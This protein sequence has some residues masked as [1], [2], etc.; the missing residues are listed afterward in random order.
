VIDL[1]V[2]Y[3]ITLNVSEPNNNIGLLKIRQ[4]D[5][6]T[7]TL[8]VQILEDALPKSYE[9]LEVF[10]CARIGQTAGLGIIEQKLH[11]SEMTDPKNGKLEYTFR[12]EDWQV[13]GRQNGYFSFRKMNDDHEYVQQFSTR[14]FTYEITK[15][16]YSDGIKEVKKDGST[17]IWTFEDLL[18]LLQEFK[19][20]GE[21]DFLEWFEE[22]R[23]QLSEDAAGNL[24]L[25]Y[26]SLR[27][28]TGTDNDFRPLE[29]N[30]SYMQ[31]VF[32]DA[33]ERA[34]PI[35]WYGASEESEDN[36]QAIQDS[37]DYCYSIGGGTVLIPKGTFKTSNGI[38]LR[39]GVNIEGVGKRLS[40]LKI[41]D[42]L[43]DWSEL[44][45]SDKTK[46]LTDV[47]IRKVG[48]D[49]NVE[50]LITKTEQWGSSARV[51][52]R[53][54]ESL[55]LT[56]DNCLFTTN[57]VW[58]VRTKAREGIFKNSD[59]EFYSTGLPDKFDVSTLWVGTA[60]NR[61]HNNTFRVIDD[62][63]FA[64][65]TAIETQGH[66][67]F[68]T[69]NKIFDYNAG[70]IFTNSTGYENSIAPLSSLGAI[71]SKIQRN[72][73]SVRHTGINLWSMYRADGNG[74]FYNIEVKD[75]NI[76]INNDYTYNS[77]PCG[78]KTHNANPFSENAVDRL[79]NSNFD[80]VEI[81]GNLINFKNRKVSQS[82]SMGDT[83]IKFENICQMTGI[84]VQRNTIKNAGHAGIYWAS[85]LSYKLVNGQWV[86][87]PD[88][89]P[90]FHENI[91]ISDNVFEECLKGLRFGRHV[92]FVS[93]IN[94]LFKQKTIYET[95]SNN[96]IYPIDQPNQD[97]PE[98]IKYNIQG[99][100][101]DVPKGLRPFIP[102]FKS[103]A[104]SA[105]NFDSTSILEGWPDVQFEQ[106]NV[107]IT[108]P[109][110]HY[111]KL[112]NGNL[113]TPQTSVWTT[114][115]SLKTTSGGDVKITQI[116]SNNL[117]LLNDASSIQPLQV[118]KLDSNFNSSY[119][120]VI[121][122]VNN[123]VFCVNNVGLKET[124][125]ADYLST[126]ILAYFNNLQT[127]NI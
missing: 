118:L 88:S 44:L 65:A 51:L 38:V 60:N 71:R 56:I 106:P 29:A 112:N 74:S 73:I 47:A 121:G 19:D 89:N 126:F 16:I 64:P 101:V 123:Y 42:G 93:I 36:L 59:F 91:I 76:Q 54:E 105:L 49:C 75:N 127:V 5:E 70:V 15:N 85:P 100:K 84:K 48:F 104:A 27:D 1:A 26:Q 22:I 79:Q 52:M 31:R 21:T 37:I 119:G 66:Y 116:I 20:S 35:T 12:A 120:I 87:D 53:V 68:V 92:R 103:T 10:F 95:P 69:D 39:D 62:S 107:A 117:L 46:V 45:T 72:I 80:G 28:K 58:A 13:L 98:N 115:G 113:T 24:M 86:I 3:P 2:R 41:K 25:L 6:E 9:G 102:K 124:A 110:G 63:V 34:I 90:N 111:L 30:L 96:M 78:I 8:V 14:D 109:F 122:V 81:S 82:I 50:N 108:V 32:N 97:Y 23:D 114:R 55:N 125:P 11:E 4:A 83:G 99:N 67:T 33:V 17:Y 57:G 40:I 18:R 7:Q 61:I 77:S 43:G 94:N